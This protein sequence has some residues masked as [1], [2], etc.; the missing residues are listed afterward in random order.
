MTLLNEDRNVTVIGERNEENDGNAGYQGGNVGNRGGNEEDQVE[1]L[2]IRVETHRY[3]G[4]FWDNL[5]LSHCFIAMYHHSYLL[6]RY[7]HSL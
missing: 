1:N 5:V 2:R 7:I 3:S 6:M 4:G